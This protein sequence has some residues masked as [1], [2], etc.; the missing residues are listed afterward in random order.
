MTKEKITET[1]AVKARLCE[2][3]DH[4]ILAKMLGFVA[5]RRMALDVRSTV[6]RRSA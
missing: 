3:A 5:D 2:T 4:Q 1:V 6:W